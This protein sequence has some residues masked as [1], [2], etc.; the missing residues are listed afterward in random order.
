MLHKTEVLNLIPVVIGVVLRWC[1]LIF[2]NAIY[3]VLFFFTTTLVKYCFSNVNVVCYCPIMQVQFVIL[4]S[5]SWG[6]LCGGW[7]EAKTCKVIKTEQETWKTTDESIYSGQKVAFEADKKKYYIWT[8]KSRNL[9]NNED[10]NCMWVGIC[11]FQ[12]P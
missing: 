8:L 4:Y 9:S 11:L 10:H 2:T 3:T 5:R 6:V 7:R 12:I 1:L